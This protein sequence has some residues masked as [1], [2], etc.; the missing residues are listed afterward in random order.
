METDSTLLAR[1]MDMRDLYV[2]GFTLQAIGDRYG[3]STRTH[4]QRLRNFEEY[5]PQR[6]R[7]IRKHNREI[8]FDDHVEEFL[9]KH[10]QDIYAAV[11]EGM[12]RQEIADTFEETYPNYSVKIWPA[13]A[14]KLNLVFNVKRT[15]HVH[16]NASVAAGV[17]YVVG[18]AYGTFDGT[19]DAE[20][21]LGDDYEDIRVHVSQAVR[22][23]TRVG[24]ILDTIAVGKL[25]VED[26]NGAETP[27]TKLQYDAARDEFVAERGRE[28]CGKLW[29]STSQTVMKRLGDGYWT[30]ALHALG[31]SSET[32]VRSYKR[33]YDAESLWETLDAYYEYCAAEGVAFVA[34]NYDAWAKHDR[35]VN[36][37]DRPSFETVR[38]RLGKWSS[39]KRRVIMNNSTG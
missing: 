18:K 29:P 34:G 6:G 10:A 30:G 19:V 23:G 33:R 35:E 14:E 16:S 39:V 31:M 24:K 28:G 11:E 13:V 25:R 5:D 15:A 26:S 38:N 20:S 22:K 12:T 32:P 7:E 2:K 17:W 4:L 27:V 37:V 36:G 9:S 21:V 1:D 8:L 3:L